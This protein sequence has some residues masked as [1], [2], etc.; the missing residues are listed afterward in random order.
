M[1]VFAVSDTGG[2]VEGCGLVGVP[3]VKRSPGKPTRNVI[4]VLMVL[5]GDILLWGNW[6]SPRMN[7]T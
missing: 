3:K 6:I 7:T 1:T 5:C 2:N 4:E